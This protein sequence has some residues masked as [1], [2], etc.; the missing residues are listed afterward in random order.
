MSQQQIAA[1]VDAGALGELSILIHGDYQPREPQTHSEPGC[2]ESFDITDATFLD[3]APIHEP[4]KT[5]LMNHLTGSLWDWEQAC[6]D[7][8]RAEA[9]EDAM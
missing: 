1:T 7:E 2:P 8:L 6:L 5:R 9:A 4:F 3:G